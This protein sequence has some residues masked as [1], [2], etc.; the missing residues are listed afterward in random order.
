[1]REGIRRHL[2]FPIEEENGPSE[3]NKSAKERKHTACVSYTTAGEIEKI[4]ARNE[5]EEEGNRN[6]NEEMKII[7]SAAK[8]KNENREKCLGEI[9]K[10]RNHEAK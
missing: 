8:R 9:S 10:N 2:K 1:M 4:S 3:E 5:E 6:E 7:S